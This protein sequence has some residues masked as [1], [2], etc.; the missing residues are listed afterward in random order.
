MAERN[1]PFLLSA[2]SEKRS[3][4][5]ER[6]LWSF[7]AYFRRKRFAGFYE[8]LS[9]V[10]SIIDFGGTP[11]IWQGVGRGDVV[12]LNIDEQ[13]APPGFTAM[14]GDARKTDFA[15]AS[16]DLAFSNSTIEHVGTWED[17]K[18][19]A[20]ELCRVGKRVYCQTP[21]HCFFFE[22]HYFT[23]F[24]HWFPSL[25]SKY[26]IVRYFTYYGLRWKPS[27]EQ[28]RDFQSHLR[29]L[30]YSEMQRLFPTCRIAKERFLGM[31]KAYIAIRL[32]SSFDS[33]LADAETKVASGPLS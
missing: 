21:A 22:P 3:N 14:K 23:P 1:V 24:L 29:L 10:D 18:E 6:I 32:R 33:V 28:V 7:S 4:V 5:V 13:H 12:L 25:I 16:F 2:S 20:R 15:D 30:N 8:F 17:Q 26:W 9:S 31:T 27:R 19:F 11:S